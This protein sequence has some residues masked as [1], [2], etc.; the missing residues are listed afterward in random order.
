MCKICE[1]HKS[2]VNV[3]LHLI[4][5]ILLIYALWQHNLTLIIVAILIALLGHFVQAFGGRQTSSQTKKLKSKKK[6]KMKKGRKNSGKKAAIELSVGTIVIIV[7]AVTM[8]ILGFVFVRSIMCGAIGL[9]GDLNDKV[10]TEIEELFGSSGGEVSCV[11][12]GGEAAALI[13]GKTSNIWCGIKAPQEAEY[14]LEVKG[15]RGQINPKTVESWIF[16]KS[17]TKRIAPGDTSPKKFIRLNVPKN[18][19]EG[20]VIFAI[21]I[22]RDNSLIN[23]KELDFSVKRLGVVKSAVC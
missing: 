7:L 13:P 8:L 18:A 5:G 17:P 14:T 2:P 1:Y 10:R 15:I 12:E 20:S 3:F 19:P 21:E 4:A 6:E 11:G 16:D 9:T 22:K 23:T